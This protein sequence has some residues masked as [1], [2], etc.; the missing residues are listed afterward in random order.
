[1]NAVKV[2]W[3]LKWC[4]FIKSGCDYMYSSKM[5]YI[6]W[7]WYHTKS[8]SEIITRVVVM[9]QIQWMQC[10]ISWEWCHEYSA[11]AVITNVVWCHKMRMWCLIECMRCYTYSGCDII[12]RL[13]VMTQIQWLLCYKYSEC[14]IIYNAYDVAIY[15][16]GDLV[17]TVGVT[18]SIQWMWGHRYSGYNGQNSGCNVLKTV[19]WCHKVRMW[20]LL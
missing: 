4:Q 14:D 11:C 19:V 13:G 1:M 15:S 6:K 10:Q 3:W 20:C 2:M 17:N 8:S 18:S 16:G 5:P 12:E 9:T 7:V